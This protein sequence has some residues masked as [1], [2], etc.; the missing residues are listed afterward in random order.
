LREKLIDALFAQKTQFDKR[1][2]QGF[3][4]FGLFFLALIKLGGLTHES[5]INFVSNLSSCSGTL[6]SSLELTATSLQG[7]IYPFIPGLAAIR[8]LMIALS[9]LIQFIEA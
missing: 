9:R 5:F 6:E 2:I 4:G 1:G 8:L 7:P 3:T